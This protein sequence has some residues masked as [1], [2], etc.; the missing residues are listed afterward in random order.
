M[1]TNAQIPIIGGKCNGMHEN[2][3]MSKAELIRAVKDRLGE[4]ASLAQAERTVAAVIEGIRRGVKDTAR[5]RLLGFGTFRIAARKARAGVN[6]KTRAEIR[7]KASNT[8]KFVPG[9]AFRELL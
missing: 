2:T 7:I 4:Q 3:V 8:I 1:V 6:P 5:V 9:K